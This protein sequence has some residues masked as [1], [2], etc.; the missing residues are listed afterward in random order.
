MLWEL[1]CAPSCTGE[2][3]SSEDRLQ[4]RRQD[5]RRLERNLPGLM[6]PPALLLPLCR[7]SSHALG[8]GSRLGH[9]LGP[10]TGAAPP[11]GIGAEDAAS[12]CCLPSTSKHGSRQRGRLVCTA[13][14]GPTRC[15]SWY[16]PLQRTQEP[17]CAAPDPAWPRPFPPPPPPKCLLTGR[18]P[19]RQP[20]PQDPPYFLLA[21][22]SVAL[23]SLED[24][25]KFTCCIYCLCH[26]TRTSAPSGQELSPLLF[27]ESPQ[28]L[29][30]LSVH[31]RCSIDTWWMNK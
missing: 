28:G 24:T 5:P 3:F 15:W 27:T 26:P 29:R 11:L 22:C 19:G 12:F 17:G 8:L 25:V 20:H 10:S 7:A 31:N 2:S 21:F 4:R 16:I 13:S 14:R 18:R 6:K 9:R 23:S 1:G 30:I